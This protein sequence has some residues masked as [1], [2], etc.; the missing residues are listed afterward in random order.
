MSPNL[1]SANINKVKATRAK[2]PTGY[3]MLVSSAHPNSDQVCMYRNRKAA[4]HE[5]CP[6][7]V[8]KLSSRLIAR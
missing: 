1:V 3:H 6:W 2:F 8:R 7:C 5:H 4:V